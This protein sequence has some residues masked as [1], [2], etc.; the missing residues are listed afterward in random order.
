MQVAQALAEAKGIL[1]WVVDEAR[2]A[3]SLTQVA[4]DAINACAAD[5]RRREEELL[6]DEGSLRQ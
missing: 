1:D 6:S 5:V 2:G 3:P 4:L